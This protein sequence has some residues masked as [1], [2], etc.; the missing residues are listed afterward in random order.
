VPKNET[1]CQP[2]TD[3]AAGTSKTDGQMRRALKAQQQAELALQRQSMQGGE[4]FSDEA[5][6]TLSSM[7]CSASSVSGADANAEGKIKNRGKDK[8]S[9][10]KT[11]CQRSES[12]CDMIC[13]S[14]FCETSACP[15]DASSIDED[16]LHYSEAGFSDV[17]KDV[18]VSLSM[19]ADQSVGQCEFDD[20]FQQ[21]RMHQIAKGFDHKTRLL[22]VMEALFGSA[23]NAQKLNSEKTLMH[24][25]VTKPT[26]DGAE[27]LWAFGAYLDK[28]P[29]TVKAYPMMLKLIYDEDWVTEEGILNYYSEAGAVV[30]PGFDVARSNAAPFLRWLESTPSS[31]G[32]DE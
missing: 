24:T 14:R 8:V 27:V 13:K 4:V 10:K 23:M 15:A 31:S 21:V 28:N 7:A 32:D 22:I 17:I 11:S 2:P 12:K 20:V 26:L 19:C 18:K 25:F 16:G 9:K 30:D 29:G 3:V 1:S 5:D 6:Q